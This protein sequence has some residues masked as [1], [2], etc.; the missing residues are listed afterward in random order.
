VG[1]VIK[2]QAEGKIKRENSSI[3]SSGIFSAAFNENRIYNFII[4]FRHFSFAVEGVRMEE[5]TGK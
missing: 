1:K 2:R 5:L 3:F 4:N